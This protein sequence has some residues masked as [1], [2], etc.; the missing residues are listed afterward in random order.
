MK[1]SLAL[2]GR[3]VVIL[4]F[5]LLLFLPGCAGQVSQGAV[6]TAQT[7]SF[8][9]A[10]SSLTLL[11][12]TW[13][14]DGVPLFWGSSKRL[15]D[16]EEE[17]LGALENA[18]SQAARYV[19][20]T[21]LSRF[22]SE[23]SS[24]GKGYLGDFQSEWN[25]TLEP[26]ILEELE[27]VQRFQDED[28]SYILVRWPGG[29]KLSLQGSSPAD[30]GKPAWVSQTPV[31]PG[32]RVSTGT[33]QR[34][35]HIIDSI[36]AADDKALEEM[37]KQIELEVTSQRNTL[38]LGSQGSGSVESSLEVAQAYVQGFYILARW[39]EPDGSSYYALGIC[40]VDNN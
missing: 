11:G 9:S 40:P 31:I 29:V 2:S 6:K 32:Y 4:L 3:V 26:G 17:W 10:G 14:R 21:G 18:A 38:D 37:V 5:S 19:G 13:S 7:G 15:Y 20:V 12:D 34:K 1:R 36:Q 39:H 35:R 8:V 24:Q 28:G 22:Y 25:R 33:V 30:R 16:R 27:E 23:R